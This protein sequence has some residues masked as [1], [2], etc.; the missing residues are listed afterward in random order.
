LGWLIAEMQE[1]MDD[2]VWENGN[3]EDRLQAALMEQDAMEAVLDEMEEEHEEAFARIHVLEAQVMNRALSLGV[4]TAC[5]AEGAEA[6]EHAGPGAQ[7]EG[8]VGQGGGR[9]CS[10]SS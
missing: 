8:Q 9:R 4:F 5:R 7:G 6:R 1:Q 3:L 10:S 2:L